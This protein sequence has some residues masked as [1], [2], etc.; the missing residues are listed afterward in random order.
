MIPVDWIGTPLNNRDI[1]NWCC[2]A[3]CAVIFLR[4]LVCSIEADCNVVLCCVVLCCVVLCCVVLCCVVL[5]CVVLC[6]VVL[7]C[8]LYC[9]VLYVMYCALLYCTAIS[10]R[11]I[12][13]GHLAVH[14]LD[15]VAI[16]LPRL[17]MP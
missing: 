3:L 16:E 11:V 1:M 6:C 9:T 8:K 14:L 2:R 15:A 13:S 5:C 4:C 10:L 7:Y 12:S 17:T